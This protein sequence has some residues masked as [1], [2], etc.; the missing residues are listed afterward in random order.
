MTAAETIDRVSALVDATD[1]PEYREWLVRWSDEFE[2]AVAVEGEDLC[3]DLADI[4][5]VFE[6]TQL[7]PPGHLIP[8]DEF[9][10]ELGFG[11]LLD[12]EQDASA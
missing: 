5:L 4:L 6:R 3:E 8:G 10:R 11:D 7:R 1:N 12:T 2:V 9:I